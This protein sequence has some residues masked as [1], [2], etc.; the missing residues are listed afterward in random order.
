MIQN[1]GCLSFTNNSAITVK[2]QLSKYMLT[3]NLISNEQKKEIKMKRLYESIKKIFCV[4]IVL[5]CLTAIMFL[6][7]KLILQNEYVNAVMQTSI[8]ARNSRGFDNK[9]SGIN[10]QINTASSIQDN[11]K[12]WS[13]LIKDI[14]E[15]TP[16]DIT[17]SLL[18]IGADGKAVQLKGTA[19]YRE[20]LLEFKQKL[21]NSGNY[22]DINLPLQ[23]ILQ[24]E[25]IN[26]DITVG[27]KEK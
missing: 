12:I 14:A 24:K 22:E 1:I 5:T 15:I 27:I 3:I 18:S 2:T 19:K 25:N 26:F 6:A 16:A 11:Y 4:S 13:P 23:N 21:E 17:L 10:H 9:I 7:S 20:S 8:I